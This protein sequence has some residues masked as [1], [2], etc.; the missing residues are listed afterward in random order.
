MYTI[1]AILPFVVTLYV[2]SFAFFSLYFSTKC[3]SIFLAFPLR[4][5]MDRFAENFED[6][7]EKAK[8][9]NRTEIEHN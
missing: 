2:G 9:K 3:F 7:L 8:S 5:A 4:E 6:S 1:S